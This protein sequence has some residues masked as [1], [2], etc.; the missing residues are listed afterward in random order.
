[1]NKQTIIQEN[2]THPGDTGSPNV[3]VALLTAEING[4]TEHLKKAKNDHS[5]RRGLLAKV[6]RRRK[7]LDYLSSEDKEAYQALLK[8]LNLR[9]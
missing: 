2:Q 3:Q 7:L 6:G 4:L 9:K 5:S 1:M 8:K